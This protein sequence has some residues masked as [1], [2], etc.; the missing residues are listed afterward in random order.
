[1]VRAP[2]RVGSA[3]PAPSADDP[4][5]VAET[6]GTLVRALA[7]ELRIEP[8][9]GHAWYVGND[10]V[11]LVEAFADHAS[12]EFWRGSS[13]EDPHHRLRGT[14]TDRRHV[15]LRSVE[16][17]TSPEL[18]G[19]LRAAIR[20]DAASPPRVRAPPRAATGGLRGGETP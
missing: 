19:L 11:F 9:W 12:V 1:M 3:R 18:V 20:R 16:E 13:L 10:L 5:R 6:V 15:T 2:K 7:P 8:R 17:A 14:G 4:K